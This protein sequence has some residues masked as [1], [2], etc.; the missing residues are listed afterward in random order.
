MG[1]QF[2]KQAWS[3]SAV[4]LEFESAMFEE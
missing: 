4:D 3:V 2:L 1:Q